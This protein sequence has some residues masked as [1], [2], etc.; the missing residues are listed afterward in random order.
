MAYTTARTAKR[1]R[2]SNKT[3]RRRETM[4]QTPK[5]SG[6]KSVLWGLIGAYLLTMGGLVLCSFLLDMGILTG[7]QKQ[8]VLLVMIISLLSVFV[9]SF[10]AAKMSGEEGWKFGLITG[11][12][13]LVIR[14]LLS[15]I[16]NGADVFAGNIWLESASCLA[17]SGIGGM[18]GKK[19][20]KK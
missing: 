3:K 19:K 7:T 6:G 16:V 1:K 15:W 13:Y 9:G 5:L 8:Y 14:F 2:A 18:L 10:V 20:I 4:I 12:L 17:M 11:A